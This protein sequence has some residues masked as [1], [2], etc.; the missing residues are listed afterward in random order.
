VDWRIILPLAPG[1]NRIFLDLV[2]DTNTDARAYARA[3]TSQSID[4]GSA[5]QIQRTAP[6]APGW[7]PIVANSSAVC[8]ISDSAGTR[9]PHW[10]H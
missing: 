1:A 7:R 4:D 10:G 8:G 3:R 6:T 5:E 2:S 9:R